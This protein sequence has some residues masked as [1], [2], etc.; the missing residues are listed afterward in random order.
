MK[1]ILVPILMLLAAPAQDTFA[2]DAEGFIRN[3]L[4]LAP[5]AIEEGSASTELDREIVKG[6]GSMKP[7][8]GEK[9]KVD[10]KEVAWKAHKTADF[11]IDFR[12]SFGAERG[13]D[14]AGYAVA[15]VWAEEEMKVKL[16]VGSNDQCKAFVNGKQVVKFSDTRTLEK[17][18][19]SGETTLLKGQ[20]VVVFK[21]LNE[22]NNWQGCARFMK[23]GAGVKNI[24]ISLAPQ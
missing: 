8:A 4:V 12:E 22:K 10:G 7:K 14:A 16:A 17:D 5:L 20:N 6:E 3:W 21:V 1:T 23:D 9:V 13:E 18:S 19:D 15:Y 2:P 11:F 24:K